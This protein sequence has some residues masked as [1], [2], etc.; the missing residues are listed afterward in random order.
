MTVRP[1][2]FAATLPA[3]S[4]TCVPRRILRYSL[5]VCL[6]VSTAFAAW[7]WFRPYAWR[8]DSAA[9][10]KIA[11]VLVTRDHSY[12]WLDVHLKVT[13]GMVHDLRKPVFL[14]N[15]AGK[16]FEPADTTLSGDDGRSTSEIWFKFWLDTPDFGGPL[17]L[18]LNDGTLVIRSGSG[19]PPLGN[20]AFRNF[21]TTEW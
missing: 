19:A 21:T 10:C 13:P 2:S 9:R 20:S 11:E 14:Q 8:S 12:F 15:S 3:R 4:A 1:F 18:H 7:G 6:L 5:L 16:A 17:S